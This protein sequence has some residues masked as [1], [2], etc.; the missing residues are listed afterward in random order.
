MIAVDISPVAS[1]L[2]EHG[3]WKLRIREVS[4]GRM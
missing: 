4:G 1:R 3:R 2:R